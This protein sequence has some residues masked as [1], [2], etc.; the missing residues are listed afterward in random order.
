MCTSQKSLSLAEHN[1][2]PVKLCSHW[3]LQFRALVVNYSV[4]VTCL[5]REPV[6]VKEDCSLIDIGTAYRV[7][8]S[9]TDA[10]KVWFTEGVWKPG[11]LF[12][13]PALKETSGKQWKFQ[14][15]IALLKQLNE[16]VFCY[17]C[18]AADVSNKENLLLSSAMSTHQRIFERSFLVS[19]TVEIL[20]VR[21]HF[22]PTETFQY[23]NLLPPYRRQES[24]FKGKTLRLM[25]TNS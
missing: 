20:D 6:Y 12:E 14:Q 25:R 3:L 19:T 23:T 24:L 10:E 18:E 16:N 15:N 1:C 8:A 22:K 7:N 17:G 11:L 4:W 21:T 9:L 13:F 2:V 5:S